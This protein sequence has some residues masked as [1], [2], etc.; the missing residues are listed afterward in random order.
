MFK[1]G[2]IVFI[3]FIAIGIFI[4]TASAEKPEPEFE[5]PKLEGSEFNGWDIVAKQLI[6]DGID[7][8]YV[9]KTF[10]RL[11]EFEFIPFKLKPVE[12]AHIY[13]LMTAPKRIDRAYEA[14][15][16]YPAVFLE[17]EKKYGVTKYAVAAI[18]SVETN[19][20][21]YFGDQP[22][23]Y[24][25]V[26]IAATLDQRNLKLNFKK[27]AEDSPDVTFEQTK[28]RGQYL[29]NTFY[30][31]ILALFQIYAE[32]PDKITELKGSVAGA[33]GLPQF[34]P[35]S[36]KDYAI[37]GNKDNDIDLFQPEDAI[38]SVAHFLSE[39][40]W[41]R[42]LSP[43]DKLKVLWHYNKSEAYGEAIIKVALNLQNRELGI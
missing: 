15:K 21:T 11:P 1:F 38:M 39:H 29:F 7:K 34:L 35:K 28:S 9:K 10:N 18:I 27:H 25:L 2:Q 16:K 32:K 36:F 41:K 6:K 42:L 8:E 14:I 33:F 17:A 37:D 31:Q 19:W 5:V 4:S 30:P 12:S 3:S 40:G 26:R 43:Q 24:R 20:G 23:L 22:V 13:N